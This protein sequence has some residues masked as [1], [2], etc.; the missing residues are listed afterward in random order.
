MFLQACESEASLLHAVIALGALD[1]TSQ[2]SP[3]DSREFPRSNSTAGLHYYHAVKAYTK[4]IHYA[5]V[6]GKKDL[7]TALLTSLA[8]LSFEA[9]YGCHD[10]ALQ[11][12]KIGTSLIKEWNEKYLSSHSTCSSLGPQD[13]KTVL[14]PVSARLSVQLLSSAGDQCPESPPPLSDNDEPES[15]FQNMPTSFSTLEEAGTFR[16]ALMKRLLKFIS[17]A[18][19]AVPKSASDSVRSYPAY[20]FSS[21]IPPSILA[22]KELLTQTVEEW[23]AASE[24]L[25]K[26]L[27]PNVSR[28]KRQQSRS[29]YRSE[30]CVCLWL[31]PA[32]RMK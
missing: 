21:P 4:A 29:S 26:R 20:V 2:T 1:K 8:T 16:D 24:P 6:A 12:I 7:R 23:L 17:N 19:S 32:L 30:L 11:Q 31:H 18:Q 15:G 28:T 3:Q 13:V 9:W 25:K 27:N 10:M 14:S 22:E 5:Q